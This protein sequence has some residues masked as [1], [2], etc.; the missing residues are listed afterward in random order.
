MICTMKELL[1]V[2]TLRNAQDVPAAADLGSFASFLAEYWENK[3]KEAVS[4]T[5]APTSR[6]VMIGTMVGSIA[7]VTW[8]FWQRGV[9]T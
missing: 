8:L 5:G 6:P 4:G 3:S 7:S 2:A 1:V 9:S